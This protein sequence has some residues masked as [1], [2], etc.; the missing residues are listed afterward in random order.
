[1]F[2]QVERLG[3]NHLRRVAILTT[4]ESSLRAWSFPQVLPYFRKIEADE[5][6]Q[7]VV[8]QYGRVHGLAGLRVADASILPECPRANTNVVTMMLSERLVD[9]LRQGL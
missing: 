1:M 2:R 9:F 7:A 5:D 3:R 6:L 4:I 8:D